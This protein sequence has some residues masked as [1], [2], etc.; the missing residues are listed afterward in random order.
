[1]IQ[2]INAETGQLS[3]LFVGAEIRKPKNTY[4]LQYEEA[5]CIEPIVSC[6]HSFATNYSS[7]QRLLHAHYIECILRA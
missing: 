5:G 6:L 7:L 4:Y 1:M 3:L 2:S